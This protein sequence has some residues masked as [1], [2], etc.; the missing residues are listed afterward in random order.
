VTIS[1]ARRNLLHGV[2]WEDNIRMDLREM[3][4][5]CGMDSSLL[6]LRTIGGP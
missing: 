6:R 4:E 3:V 5:S 1:F 2:R